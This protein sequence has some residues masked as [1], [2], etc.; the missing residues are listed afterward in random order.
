MLELDS[1]KTFGNVIY[2]NGLVAI[3]ECLTVRVRKFDA[4]PHAAFWAP[5]SFSPLVAAG[6]PSN[7]RREPSVFQC[8]SPNWDTRSHELG[9]KS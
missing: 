3:V 4:A 7:M 9:H 8:V 6:H 5:Q 1:L 2:A